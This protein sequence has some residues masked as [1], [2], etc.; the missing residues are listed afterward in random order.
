MA[1]GIGPGAYQV[2]ILGSINVI[3]IIVL[4]GMFD[5]GRI[6]SPAYGRMHPREIER[7]RRLDRRPR[8]AAEVTR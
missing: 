8:V 6:I 3:L 2:A 4:F 7:L 5:R 1:A